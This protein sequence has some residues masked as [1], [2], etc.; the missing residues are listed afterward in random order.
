MGYLYR[1]LDKNNNILYIGKTS[2]SLLNRLKGHNHLPD[3]CYKNINKI[4]YKEINNLSDLALLEI[5]YI[6]TYLPQYNIDSK[7]TKPLSI[8]L[9]DP[10]KNWQELDCHVCNINLNTHKQSKK[11]LLTKEEVRRRQQI[12]I[13]QAKQNGKYKGRKRINIDEGAFKA[14]C[15]EWREGKRT[16]V[17]IMR[18]FNISSPTFY[19][20]I[21]EWGL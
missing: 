9:I 3:K 14:Y 1:F 15:K 7:G 17:S 6:N 16:A 8:K 13:E 21:H 2:R 19:R 12:G 4:E 10:Y 20:R 18:K 5:Y 11:Q